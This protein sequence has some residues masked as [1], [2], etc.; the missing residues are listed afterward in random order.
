[1][2]CG[3][4]IKVKDPN[5]LII[6]ID[7][8]RADRLSCYGYEKIETPNID[9]LAKEG[10]LF[11][12]AVC[13][14]PLTFPSHCSIF[15][16]RYPTAHGAR[17][18][19]LFKLGGE[20]VTLA[21]ILSENGFKTAAFVGSY[22]LNSGFGLEQGFQTFGDI[23]LQLGDVQSMSQVQG[24]RGP[25]RVAEEVNE[26]F[27]R[28]ISK[29]GEER[30]FAWVHYY[31]PHWPYHPPEWSKKEVEGEGY[32]REVSYSDQCV[33]DI[34]KVLEERDFLDNTVVVFLSDHG[35]SLGEHG[36]FAHGIFI[37]DCCMKVPLIIRAPWMI[38]GGSE[39]RGLFE[40]VDIMPTLLE[41]L[42]ISVPSSVQGESFAENMLK[43]RTEEGKKE[44]YGETYMPT[45]EY[46]WSELKSIRK[47]GLKYIEAPIPELYDL[48]EDPG[49]LENLYSAGSYESEDLKEDLH[50]MMER[51]TPEG[52]DPFQMEEIDEEKVQMLKSLGYLS[53]DYF[54]EGKID[55]GQKR[56][57]PKLTIEEENILLRGKR[58]MGEGRFEEA[59][60]TFETVLSKNPKNYQAR[61]FTIKVLI[62]ME[63]FSRAEEEASRAIQI[64]GLDQTAKTALGAELWNMNGYLMERKNNFS[65]AEQSYKKALEINP[66]NEIAFSF[67]ANFYITQ[68]KL[69]KAVEVVQK[70]LQI[71]PSNIM[72]MSYLFKL[73]VQKKDF[74][75]QK[76]GPL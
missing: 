70:A 34:L 51:I 18:N 39:Y 54:R 26:D 22:V 75:G 53:G 36:E 31:D 64:A 44:S 13:Q 35:E 61:I 6:V 43:G 58:M 50:A 57:D 12:N 28:W 25:E 3:H 1:M 16:G 41:L 72:A 66:N 27:F 76:T 46:G 10:M 48:E 23:D 14:T 37:Y 4:E 69:D 45:F 24:V 56:I 19:G 65:E 42:G 11:A 67:L 17:H 29:V 68:K 30:F 5:L 9:L 47:S 8:L 40:T 32:D 49:E 73:Q 71:S 74:G 33:G 21:E 59:I 7:T 38:E 62:A 15:T 60:A 55:P 63:N 52:A 2:F 20:E